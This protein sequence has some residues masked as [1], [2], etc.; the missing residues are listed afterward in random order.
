MKIELIERI[1]GEAYL[2]WRPDGRPFIHFESSRGIEGLLKGRPAWDALVIAP[3]V[4]GIC[5]HAHLAAAVEAL[6]EAIGITPT[7]K[8]QAIRQITRYGEMVQN[9]LKWFYLT[10]L[11]HFERKE[12]LTIHPYILLTTS[13]IALFAGQWPHSS[14]MVP[15]GV[16]CDPSGLDLLRAK[17][18]LTRLRRGFDE[19]QKALEW[20]LDRLVQE[21]I[22]SLGKSFDRFIIL[23]AKSKLLATKASRIDL[24]QIQLYEQPPSRALGVRYKGRHYETGPLARMMLRNH[25]HVR[26]LHR[27]Y[28]DG[29]ATR[30]SARVLEIGWLLDR[31]EGL[32]DGMVLDQPSAVQA[33][34]QF[35]GTGVGIVEAARGSLLHKVEVKQGRISGY[36]IITPTQWNLAN[37]DEEEPGVAIEALSRGPKELSDLIFRSFDVCSVCT[38]H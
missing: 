5:G 24:G 18:Y 25:P 32:L 13:L 29:L 12:F 35:D 33:P 36:Q 21:G 4:C 37:G 1:E 9:H 28:K 19:A 27:R 7:P 14:Y 2:K 26:R 34:F 31:M 22:A 3:R 16:T 38:T 20:L 11:P 23:S 10:I 17:G 15:G 8:A 6:E 30:I